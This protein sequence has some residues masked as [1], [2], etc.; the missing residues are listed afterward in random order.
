MLQET[1]FN[2]LVIIDD[3]VSIIIINLITEII[4]HR[5]GSANYTVVLRDLELHN[6]YISTSILDSV[7]KIYIAMPRNKI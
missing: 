4:S 2:K 1:R 3:Y 5:L 6:S 7:L